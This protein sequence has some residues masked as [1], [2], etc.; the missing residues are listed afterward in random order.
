MALL[1]YGE[2]QVLEVF[3]NT[4]PSRLYWV[5]FPREDLRQAVETVKRIFTKE[6]IGRQLVGQSSYTLFMNIQDG[7]NSRKNVVIFDTQDRL[8]DKIDEITSM[9]S[10][11]TAQGSSQN[12]PFK[13]KMYH[14]KRRGQS[15]NYYEQ[16]RYQNRY[17]SNSGDRRMSY[18]DRVKYG[19][20]YR[21]R[22]Q[23]DPNYK[24]DFRRGILEE[25]KIMEVRILEVDIEVT[26]EMTT[27]EE[28]DAGPEKD[29]IQVI[30]EEMN[31][32]VLGPDEVQ[33]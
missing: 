24:S 5:F 25:H 23:Y 18:R 19:Q 32:I 21:G 1:G 29:S 6:K 9:M 12:R 13:P 10:K 15:R 28:V 8:D 11:L 30:L 31:K 16:D 20:K 7:Y 33:E 2:P 27:L 17:R 14:G 22:S 3:K 26:L 4:L